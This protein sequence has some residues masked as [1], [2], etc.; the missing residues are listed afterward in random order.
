VGSTCNWRGR[1]SQHKSCCNNPNSKEYNYKIYQII[2]A[3]GGWDNFKMIQIGFREKLT[4]RQA[5]GIEEEYR[6]ELRAN[7]NSIKCSSGYE[8]KKEYFANYKQEHREEIN[9]KHECEICGGKFT[10]RNKARHLKSKKHERAV[11]I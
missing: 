5:E 6:V 9:A 1:K 2:R 11:S 7:M 8:T 10:T 4:L 3:N